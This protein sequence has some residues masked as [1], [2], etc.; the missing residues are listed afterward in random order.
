VKLPHA[1]ALAVAFALAA[2][3]SDAATGGITREQFIRANVA[4]R[5]VSD[6]A[7]QVDT[8]RARAL[9]KEKVTPAQLRAWLGAHQG[10]AELLAE[11]W[12][13]ISRRV[14]ARDSTHRRPPP[15]PSGYRVTRA[16]SSPP[17]PG[18][19]GAPM[20]ATLPVPAPTPR[21][22]P[23]SPIQPPTSRPGGY[24]TPVPTPQV[25][26]TDTPAP[27]PTPPDSAGATP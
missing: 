4:M 22:A 5:T 20:P 23:A 1:A 2:C 3:G 24:Q 10:D 27:A 9:R 16:D 8:L 21:P 14:D 19:P 26:K 12:N 6:S 17:P 15:P 25:T 18:A 7:P 13:E 11:T